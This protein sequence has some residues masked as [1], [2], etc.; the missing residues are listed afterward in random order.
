LE[1]FFP[2]WCGPAVGVLTEHIQ[3]RTKITPP[4]APD[5]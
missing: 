2:E 1:L 4:A 5:Q 3:R